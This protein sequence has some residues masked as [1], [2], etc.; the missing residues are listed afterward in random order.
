MDKNKYIAPEIIVEE[1]DTEVLMLTASQVE[2]DTLEE[3]FIQRGG[4][5]RGTWGNLWDKGEY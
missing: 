3:G 4:G 2:V 5:R 1:L